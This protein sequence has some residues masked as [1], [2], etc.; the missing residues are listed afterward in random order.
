MYAKKA[1]KATPNRFVG[2]WQQ[3]LATG[4]LPQTGVQANHYYQ[5][6]GFLTLMALLLGWQ[7]LKLMR[8]RGGRTRET[9]AAY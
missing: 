5:W 1:V 9:T 7:V 8:E 3:V 4:R 6:L 2:Q